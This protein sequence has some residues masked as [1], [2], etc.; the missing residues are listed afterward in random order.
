M[1]ADRVPLLMT[2]ILVLGLAQGFAQDYDLNKDSL[3]AR[4]RS[5]PDDTAKITTLIAL[6]H[7]YEYN[8]QDTAVFYYQQVKQLSEKLHFPL[9]TVRYISNI[10]GVLEARGKLDSCLSLNLQAIELCDRY[11][12]GAEQ[13]AKALFNT[14]GVYHYMDDKQSALDYYLKALPLFENTKKP[15]WLSQITGNLSG[16]YRSLDEPEKALQYGQQSLDYARKSGDQGVIAAAL[17]NLGVAYQMTQQWQKALACENECYRIAT[18]INYLNLQSDAL[19]NMGD[20]LKRSLANPDDYIA[21]YRKILPLA[22]SL[23]DMESKYLALYGIA[24][25]AFYKSQYPQ[26]EAQA[27]QALEYTQK[28]NLPE[29]TMRLMALLRDIANA[30][31]RHELAF[32][33]DMAEDS[34]SNLVN[35]KDL[36]K[37]IENLEV[38]YETQKKQEL[39]LKQQLII[40]QKS[41]QTLRQRGWLI[42]S[43][44]GI[45]MLLLLIFGGYRVYRQ[46]QNTIRL[47]A[48]LDGQKQERQRIAGE[49][50]DDIGSGLTSLL[51]LSRTDGQN[52]GLTDK[53]TTSVQN[54]IQKINE[55]I[56]AMNPEH[57]SLESLIA[58]VRLHVADMLDNANLDYDFDI[59]DAIPAASLSQKARRNIYLA[60][61]EAVHNAIRHAG[62]SKVH[63]D[64]K[65]DQRLEI[66]IQDNGKGFAIDGFSKRFGNG[67]KNMQDRITA[68]NGTFSVVADA[69]ACIRIG[70]PLFGGR[71]V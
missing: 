31:G 48:L 69:G 14:G 36:K 50:H 58:Y 26:A 49:L 6:G 18:K 45:G 28:N 44:A 21:V 24:S 33:Y 65:T 1:K 55:I 15:D 47:T 68:I 52:P 4:L 23:G 46:K 19:M 22:D 62:A 37:N 16:L 25:G 5:M 42:A 34:V 12:L 10:T 43:T 9:G 11:N 30:T 66:A 35:G 8:A 3:K 7:L 38:K 40:Q 60:V 39:I 70:V 17:N 57:D 54:L 41:E 56:W 71:P 29:V 27:K 51:F 20:I 2:F 32:H 13:K 64:I 59:P 67:M 61:K 53:L 63:I